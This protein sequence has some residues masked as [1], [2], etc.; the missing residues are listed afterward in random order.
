MSELRIDYIDLDELPE[1]TRNARRHDLD[2]IAGAY[3]RLG[4]TRPGLI[5]ERTGRLV[6]GHGRRLALR[7]DLERGGKPPKGIRQTTGGWAMPVVRGWASRDDA[8]ADAAALADNKVGESGGYDDDVLL[9]ILADLAADAPDLLRAAHFD[10]DDLDRLLESTTSPAG[11]DLA[12]LGDDEDPFAR[13]GMSDIDEVGSTREEE[14]GD[15]EDD[16]GPGA[17]DVTPAWR[18]LQPWKATYHRGGVDGARRVREWCHRYGIPTID[19]ED[20]CAEHP[21]DVVLDHRPGHAPDILEA[22]RWLTRDGQTGRL[23]MWSRDEFADRFVPANEP[24]RRVQ[25]D[26]KPAQPGRQERSAA[27]VPTAAEL[28]RNGSGVLLGSVG[29]AGL[30]VSPVADALDTAR[31][32]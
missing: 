8:E 23:E 15:R 27:T 26:A 11:A 22:G 10:S 32:E 4:F 13:P 24:A 31:H 16:D 3:R 21:D 1:A 14:P 25:R 30:Q 12:G 19:P 6:A 5:D 29:P 2:A 18:T 9:D 20:F 28:L 17:L 7:R